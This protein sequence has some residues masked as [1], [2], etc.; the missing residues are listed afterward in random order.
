LFVF[1]KFTLGETLILYLTSVIMVTSYQD[2]Y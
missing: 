1:Q 2:F